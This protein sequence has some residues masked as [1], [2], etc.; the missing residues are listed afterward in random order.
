M[1]FQVQ[2]IPTFGTFDRGRMI[3]RIIGST[4]KQGLARRIELGLAAGIAW[5]LPVSGTTSGGAD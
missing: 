2:S 1:L 5:R 3:D 4:P